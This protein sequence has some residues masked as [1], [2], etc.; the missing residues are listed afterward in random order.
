MFLFYQILVFLIIFFSPIILLFRIFK[1]KED[2]IRFVEKFS[3]FSKKRMNGNLVWFHGSSVGEILSVIPLIENLEKNKSIKQIL[4]T[5]STLSSSIVFKKFKFKKVMHQFFPIDVFFLTNKF[6]NYWKPTIAIFI[7]SEIWPCMFIGIKKRRIPLVLINARITKKTF[8]KWFR[9]KNFTYG[10]FN[11]ISFAYPQNFETL[12][13]LKKLKVS[14]IKLIG[15][16]K[17]SENRNNDTKILDKKI[18]NEFRSRK[19][20][21]ASSTHLGEELICAK[22]HIK[23]K[24][25]FKN[26]LTII[27]PRHVQRSD[28]I[29]KK[30]EELNLRVLLRSSNKK[31]LK[32]IDIY[33]VDT[34]G[35]TNKFYKTTNT[36][37]L[38]GSFIKH[39][40]QNPIEPARLGANII[41]GPHVN[42]FKE[43]YK[44]LNSKKISYQANNGSQLTNILEKT[45]KDL[46][47]N[48]S[49]F[50]KIKNVG[51]SILKITTNEINNLIRNEIKKT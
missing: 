42:N 12:K 27:I 8:D 23:L 21:C 17:Y 6:L 50:L 20:W 33:L 11:K 36:V 29:K 41:H 14:N 34:Y 7:E 43:V 13:Y 19:I 26:L 32:E 5:S 30:L 22:S 45:I 15:N 47:N 18:L 3:I 31:K 38:G 1:K 24:K 16:L 35:E 10:I 49:K 9:F 40:G 39:G 28:E 25:K 46:S 4:V 51:K 44:L 2:K 48:K 37:F